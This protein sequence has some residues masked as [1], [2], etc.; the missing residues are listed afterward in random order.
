MGYKINR[1]SKI[2]LLNRSSVEKKSFSSPKD[3]IYINNA[4][5]YPPGSRKPIISDLNIS[6]NPNES[7]LVFRDEQK[8]KLANFLRD[9]KKFLLV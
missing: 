1:L 4:D 9:S 2:E 3:C 8:S 6:V 5:L 7:L